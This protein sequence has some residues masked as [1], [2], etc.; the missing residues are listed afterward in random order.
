[1]PDH[2]VEALGVGPSAFAVSPCSC[3]V[4]VFMPSVT[5]FSSALVAIRS[6]NL[7]LT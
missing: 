1:M 5:D 3:D 7:G 6:V 2:D 4:L